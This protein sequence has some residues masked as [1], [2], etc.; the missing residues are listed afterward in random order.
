MGFFFEIPAGCSGI[1]LI[2]HCLLV[3]I[4][5]YVFRITEKQRLLAGVW[6]KHQVDTLAPTAPYWLHPLMLLP[7]G[8]A[9]LWWADCLAKAPSP[10][11]K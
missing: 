5:D 6:L 7:K 11:W 3:K 10:L 2:E 9:G 4:Y 8:L 1:S